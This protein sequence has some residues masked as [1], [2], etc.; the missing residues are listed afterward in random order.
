MKTKIKLLA[1]SLLFCTSNIMA[2]VFLYDRSGAFFTGGKDGVFFQADV[3]ESGSVTLYNRANRLTYATHTIDG[4][5]IE[6]F[7]RIIDT[8][9]DN[10][11]RPLAERIVND[12]FSAAE[13]S[14]IQPGQVL[15]IAMFICPQTGRV[16]EVRFGFSNRSGYATIPVDT[17]RRI[18]LA[19]REQIRFTPTADGRRL[20]YIFRTWSHQLVPNMP[21]R[22]NRLPPPPPIPIPQS[23]PPPSSPPPP[24]PPHD[25]PGGGNNQP[26]QTEIGG[27][28]RP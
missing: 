10:W 7:E 4:R 2:Q 5:P 18:E 26:P 13:R 9:P 25:P 6:L 14:R 3:S 1:F 28:W 11:T 24:P 12:A 23:P 20:N 27:E 15:R 22:R 16:M 8:E 17:F 19:L 21:E